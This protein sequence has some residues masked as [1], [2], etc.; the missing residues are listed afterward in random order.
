[1]FMNKSNKNQLTYTVWQEG[2]YFVAQCLNVDV[3]SFG[4]T[5]DE[6]LQ[7]V[8]EAVSLYMEDTTKSLLDIQRPSI[9]VDSLDYA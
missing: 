7:N 4:N 5:Y 1:M 9:V 2:D 3:A 6:A 8:R